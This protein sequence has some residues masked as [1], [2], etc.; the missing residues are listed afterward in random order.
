MRFSRVFGK[1]LFPKGK[2]G[3]DFVE[4]EQYITSPGKNRIR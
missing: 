3:A 4:N 2:N 1:A